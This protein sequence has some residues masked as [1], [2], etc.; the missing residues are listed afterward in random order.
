MEA[1]FWEAL[2]HI[3][4][5]LF[6]RRFTAHRPIVV[7]FWPGYELRRTRFNTPSLYFTRFFITPDPRAC[8]CP[9]TNVK[10]VCVR[11]GSIAFYICWPKERGLGDFEALTFY[12]NKLFTSASQRNLTHVNFFCRVDW[13]FSKTFD[14]HHVFELCSRIALKRPRVIPLL[15]YILYIQFKHW[16]TVLI[17]FHP[18]INVNK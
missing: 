5:S 18:N 14:P 1:L 8:V 9:A 11:R 7:C 12:S 13:G 4:Q 15:K 2:N 10:C 3:K 16:N 6:L 17:T